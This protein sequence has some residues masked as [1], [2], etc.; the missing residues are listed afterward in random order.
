MHI[1]YKIYLYNISTILLLIIVLNFCWEPL[2]DIIPLTFDRYRMDCV[3][4]KKRKNL[5]LY[6]VGKGIANYWIE[7]GWNTLTIE[8]RKLWNW[9]QV[10]QVIFFCLHSGIHSYIY[11]YIIQFY[12]MGGG[13][14]HVCSFFKLNFIFRIINPLEDEFLFQNFRNEISGKTRIIYTYNFIR[15][16]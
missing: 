16:N 10:F 5:A 1:V 11:I 2:F 9:N 15:V 14:K 3:N 4:D 6:I 7:E 12:Y 8:H 13:K